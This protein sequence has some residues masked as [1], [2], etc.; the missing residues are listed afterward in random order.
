MTQSSTQPSPL[1][2]LT[3]DLEYFLAM[4]ESQ[5]P[6]KPDHSSQKWDQ[7]AESWERERIQHRKGEERVRSTVAYLEQRGLLRPE[8]RVA[9][10]GCG[11]GRFAAAFAH[12]VQW[13][14]GF[15][16]SPKMVQYGMDHVRRAG[17]DN[18]TLHTC[19]FQTLNV[20]QSGLE[21]AFDLV[22]A[23]LTPAIHGAAGLQKVMDM[24]RAYCCTVTHIYHHNSVRRQLQRELFG[25]PPA[26]PWGGRWFYSLFNVL[27]LMGY[28]P[29]T[30]YDHQLQQRRLTPSDDY[31]AMM[32]EQILPAQS[33]TPENHSRILKWLH[34]HAD[35]DGMVTETSRACYGRILWDIRVRSEPAQAQNITEEE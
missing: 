18:V 23:S 9:D 17:L 12:K 4:Q 29:E 32:M 5:P 26:S 8:Y 13:V 24:S 19:D 34:D 25:L 20:Q 35:Q 2:G 21:G 28:L 6:N 7:R 31:A 33:Q 30:S 3:G 16:L 15:D 22:F 27:L 14:T 10:I 11:P 1:W